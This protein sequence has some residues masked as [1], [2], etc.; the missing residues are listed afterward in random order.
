M[1]L[2]FLTL[3]I[4]LY[5]IGQ[6]TGSEPRDTATPKAALLGHWHIAGEDTH[7]YFDNKGECEIV[8]DGKISEMISASYTILSQYV[9]DRKITMRIEYRSYKGHPMRGLEQITLAGQI[10]ED[11]EVFTG[12][13]WSSRRK[14]VFW[15]AV[16]NKPPIML[17][18]D[19]SQK[20]WI[21]PTE[22]TSENLY[23][24]RSVEEFKSAGRPLK[25]KRFH[26]KFPE[27]IVCI[28]DDIGNW[29]IRRRDSDEKPI[30]IIKTSGEELPFID[31]QVEFRMDMPLD[32]RKTW[33][34]SEKTLSLKAKCDREFE[35]TTLF[36]VEYIKD[37]I[38]SMYRFPIL[39]RIYCS[40]KTGATYHNISILYPEALVTFALNSFTSSFEKD[41]KDFLSITNTLFSKQD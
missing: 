1:K 20:P 25:S 27:F 41:D 14:I 38:L 37:E 13:Y 32:V 8:S 12:S 22:S 39:D 31:V 17:Y 2:F 16:N 24:K 7:I 36:D 3:L 40:K 34:D 30:M 15:N 29:E 9:Q 26:N 35:T 23:R 28:P 6:A 21:R 18:I 5:L 10:S 19:S 11:G 33:S 4:H